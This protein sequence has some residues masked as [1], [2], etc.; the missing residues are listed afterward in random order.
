MTRFLRFA[1]LA[2]I[3]SC[4]LAIPFLKSAA[5]TNNPT[6]SVIVEFRDDPAAV[7]SAKLKQSGAVPTTDQVQSYRNTLSAAQDQFLNSL[8]SRGI[9]FQLQTIA[10]KDASGNVAGSVAARYTLV[11]NGVTLTVPE[12]AAP[13]IAAIPRAKKI[14]AN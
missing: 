12:A 5:V 11:Y 10:I 7:Y 4:S 13:T 3:A 9:N 1:A 14:H 6:V 8:R 2:V